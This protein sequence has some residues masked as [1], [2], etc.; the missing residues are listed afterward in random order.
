MRVDPMGSTLVQV[1]GVVQACGQPDLPKRY[2]MPRN[3]LGYGLLAKEIGDAEPL[4]FTVFV[5]E[6]ASD[7]AAVDFF[8]Y[9]FLCS[10]NQVNRKVSKGAVVQ[11]SLQPIDVLGVGRLWC[12]KQIERLH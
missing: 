5:D 2:N 8:S 12:A 11:V 1:I 4:Q 3:A 6:L 9:T 7:P 10:R